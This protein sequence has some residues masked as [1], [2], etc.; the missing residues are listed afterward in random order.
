M[1]NMKLTLGEKFTFLRQNA[2]KTEKETA[3]YLNLALSTY[4]K[5]EDDFVYPADTLIKKAAKLYKMTYAE[6][7]AV[8]EE[9]K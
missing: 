2:K 9:E 7:L 3:E 4:V 5:I 1:K 8:G 6:L